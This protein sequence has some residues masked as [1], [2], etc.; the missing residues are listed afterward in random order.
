MARKSPPAPLF[1]RGEW[2]RMV[3]RAP[4]LA[5]TAEA[6]AGKAEVQCFDFAPPFEKGGLGGI[7]APPNPH[8][9]APNPFTANFIPT[10]I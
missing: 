5:S 8:H 1:Q 4:V 6:A 9:P 7:Y 10:C 2:M 3:V